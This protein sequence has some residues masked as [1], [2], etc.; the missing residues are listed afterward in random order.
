VVVVDIV[1]DGFGQ[2]DYVFELGAERLV[3]EIEDAVRGMLPA[4]RARSRGSS[5][6]ARSHGS[7]T[8]KELHEKVLPP[9]DDDVAKSV[10]EYDTLAE[11]RGGHRGAHPRAARGAGD[12]AV[13]AGGGRRA[14]EGVERRPARA[15]PSR[16]A[17]GAPPGLHP[18]AAAA[19]HRPGTPTAGD[20]HERGRARGPPAQEAKQ[21]IARE[22]LLEAVADELGL[23]VTDDDIRESCASRG[24]R[25][26]HRRVLRARRRRSRPPDLRLRKA[27]DRIAAEVKPSRRNR[28]KRASASG[29]PRR[30]GK[31]E[32][33]EE[34][35][36][37]RQQGELK[38]L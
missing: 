5:A 17:R 4:R 1:S 8:L 19:R 9:L 27:L 23:E 3:D 14:R 6:T 11:L 38:C 34:V 29:H 7:V 15:C 21:S 2:R 25:R 12:C 35:V 37:P 26:G 36:D 33:V 32:R 22:L 24:G 28:P 16:C 20:E 13:P 30:K 18:H 31:D 10:S